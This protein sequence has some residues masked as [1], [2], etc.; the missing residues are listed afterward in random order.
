MSA[1][2]QILIVDDHPIFRHGL[3]RLINEQKDFTVCSEAVDAA[4]AMQ[5]VK[6]GGVDI[7]VLDISLPGTSGIDLCQML[8][9]AHPRI[10]VLIV[11]MHKDTLYAERAIRAGAKGYVVKQEAPEKLLEALRAI[12]QGISYFPETPLT[13]PPPAQAGGAALSTLSD[14]ELQMFQ[15]IG[16]GRSTRQIAQELKLSVKTIESYR[17]HIKEKMGLESGYA[18]VQA[19]IYWHHFEAQSR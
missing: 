3:V 10:V 12:S 5:Q 13:S 18:L 11:S 14:R 17:A 19:A 1:K 2:K 7:A 6:R 9:H 4:Q 8:R 15:M 16:A